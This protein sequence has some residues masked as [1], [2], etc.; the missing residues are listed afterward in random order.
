[1]EPDYSWADEM[2]AIVVEACTRARIDTL[3]AGV[4]VFYSHGDM[5]IMEHPNGDKFEIRYIPN[6]PGD[7]N[8]EVLRKLEQIAA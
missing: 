3:Q 1:M 6:A 2:T 4:P 5:D 7:C 8:Y